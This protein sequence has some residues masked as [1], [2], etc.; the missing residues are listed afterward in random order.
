[1]SAWRNEAAAA[2]EKY[3]IPVDLYLKLVNQESGFNPGAV[4]PA[5]A[6][7]LGQLMPGTAA[8][9]GVDPNDPMQNLDGSARYLAEQYKRFGDWEM[10]LAAYNA[11]P[12]AVQKYGGIPPYDETQNYVRSI[13]GGQNPG[14]NSTGGQN[15]MAGLM[16]GAGTGFNPNAMEQVAE[17][18]PLP[19]L[20]G[21][22][23]LGLAM[24]YGQRRTA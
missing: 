22:I 11:G 16:N 6:I 24:Q 20:N 3:G 21:G 12:G 5:G 17:E 14:Q 10:A 15:A 13:M 1:M 9:L 23:N 8:D 7:G 19:P 4:S 2:A 18:P